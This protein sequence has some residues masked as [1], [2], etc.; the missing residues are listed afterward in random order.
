MAFNQGEYIREYRKE[1]YG[2]MEILVRK[3]F[4]EEIKAAAKAAGQSVNEYVIEA[5][6]ARMEKEK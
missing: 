5:V 4:K 1:N 6:K 3:D 2:R